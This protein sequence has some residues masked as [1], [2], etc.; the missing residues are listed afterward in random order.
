MEEEKDSSVSQLMTFDEFCS[1]VSEHPVGTLDDTFTSSSDEDS[2]T[3]T[4]GRFNDKALTQRIPWFRGHEIHAYSE[5]SYFGELMRFLHP[6]S[7]LRLLGHNEDNHEL[8]VVWRYGLLVENGWA[9]E[10]EFVCGARRFQTFLVATEGSSDS[11]ILKHALSLLRP[12]I[13]DFFRFIDMSEGHPFPGTGNL[14][15]FAKGLTNIDVQNNLIFLFD[16]DAEGA[17][18]YKQLQSLNMPPNMRTMML[19]SLEEFAAFNTRGPE[20]ESIADINGRAAAIE[21]Y[22]D[23]NL[24]K[25][26]PATV[27]WTN[28][29]K[30]LDVYQGSLDHKESYTKEFMK[31]T[32]DTILKKGYRT[33]KLIV[34]INAL[35]DECCMAAQGQ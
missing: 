33:D 9:S 34:V 29:K 13:S 26:Q 20:G 14:V 24:T 15:K 3:K 5:L 30:E 11:H 4:R 32:S 25:Y 19:P 2:E 7:I 21:C 10:S 12:D 18:A 16:N 1:F 31:K 22:L 35:I 6:Y 27:V 17:Y 28:Y 23:L 8:D